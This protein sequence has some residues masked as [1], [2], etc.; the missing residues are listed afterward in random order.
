MASAIVRVLVLTAIACCTGCYHYVP[1]EVECLSTTT[2][3]VIPG[4]IIR[5]ENFTWMEFFQPDQTPVVTGPDGKA[6]VRV[7]VNYKSGKAALV[8]EDVR[9][10]GVQPIT[11]HS[12][13]WVV[14][15][16]S[17]YELDL[18][19]SEYRGIFD[20]ATRAGKRPNAIHLTV[21]FVTMSE[22]REKE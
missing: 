18:P 16:P 5:S 15:L 6:T 13:E 22:H 10:K 20:A 1:V 8:F 2:R 12:E 11:F 17:G 19:V 14:N 3:Q 21:Q 4:I 7:C 9:L